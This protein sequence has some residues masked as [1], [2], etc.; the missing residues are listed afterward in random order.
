MSEH[1]AFRKDDLQES[2]DSTEELLASG[3]DKRKAEREQEQ[4]EREL[5]AG[6]LAALLMLRPNVVQY[7]V[8]A[9]MPWDQFRAALA[10][11]LS[12]GFVIH[13]IGAMAAVAR[14]KYDPLDPETIRQ[15]QAYRDQFISEYEAETRKAM[16]YAV[17]WAKLRGL[18]DIQANAL[19]A[20]IAGLNSVQMGAILRQFDSRKEAGASDKALDR[21]L[22]QMARKMLKERA[23]MTAQS[24]GWRLYQLGQFAAMAQVERKYGV[25]VYK[26]W[27][28]IADERLCKFCMAIPGLNLKPIPLR[29]PFVT[30]KGPI[31]FAPA[32][33]VC[34]C[35]HNWTVRK[36]DAF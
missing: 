7:R 35:F 10:G 24:E 5:L 34:R 21:M 32:H 2:D 15:Q 22:D 12:T 31:M 11:A 3:E 13:D 28:V 14:G 1:I 4:K 30:T 19:L 26:D 16:Q 20:K 9:S 6:I 27:N 17:M 23:R 18:D 33:P 36:R 25:A 8:I 29:Q